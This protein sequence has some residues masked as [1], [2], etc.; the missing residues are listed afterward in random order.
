MAYKPAKVLLEI[1]AYEAGGEQIAVRV[2][3]W[4][5][6]DPMLSKRVCFEQDDVLVG[7]KAKGIVLSDFKKILIQ[8]EEILR[9]LGATALDFE[10]VGMPVPVGLVEAEPD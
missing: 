4:E 9:A 2:E 6:G 10:D 8:S 1:D 5:R 7:G 3:K